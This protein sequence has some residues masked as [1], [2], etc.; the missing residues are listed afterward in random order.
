[1][2]REKTNLLM[3]MAKRETPV[4]ARCGKEDRTADA[5]PEHCKESEQQRSD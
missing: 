3:K 4:S 5:V 2:I 1:L